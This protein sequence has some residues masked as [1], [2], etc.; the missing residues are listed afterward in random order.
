MTRAAGVPSSKYW[1]APTAPVS[2]IGTGDGFHVRWGWFSR[3]LG[4]PPR[5]VT[6]SWRRR[7]FPKATM[8]RDRH[9][10]LPALEA[11]TWLRDHVGI[12]INVTRPTP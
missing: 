10:Y 1:C 4:Q 9:W 11:A 8:H 12:E 6:A 2:V 3:A 5:S 7:G